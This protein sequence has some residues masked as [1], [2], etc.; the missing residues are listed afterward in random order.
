ML[1]LLPRTLRH[2]GRHSVLVKASA[3]RAKARRAT[4]QPGMPGGIPVPAI[5]QRCKRLAQAFTLH[6]Q[7]KPTLVPSYLPLFWVRI[8]AI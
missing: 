5:C 2:R 1:M 7:R 4:R 6:M 3:V 8:V